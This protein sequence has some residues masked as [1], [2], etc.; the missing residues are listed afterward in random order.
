MMSISKAYKCIRE[1]SRQTA[2]DHVGAYAAQSSF[3]FI[4]AIFPLFMLLL[5]L[6]KYT[7]VTEHDLAQTAIAIVPDTL[8]PLI[9]RI[10]QE[11]YA[12]S[13]FAIISLTAIAALW[14]SSRVILSLIRGLNSIF[15]IEEKRGYFHLRIVASFYTIIFLIVIILSLGMMVFGNSLLRFFHNN[16]PPLYELAD[17]I[18]G[19]RSI[20]IPIILTVAFMYLYRIIPNQHYRFFDHLPG[21][22]FSSLGWII[23]SYVYSYYIDNYA[24][25]RLI[26]G[27]LTTV[28]F[29][30]LWIYICIYILFIGAEINIQYKEHIHAARQFITNHRDPTL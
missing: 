1:F 5:N 8:D 13:N 4:I 29:L 15:G 10:I 19:L 28:V 14:S 25:S 16:I 7:P 26:Y 6:I 3:F 23:F 18:I 30:M 12:Q 20:Y 2:Y 24:G 21:A 9:A 22:L 27:S 11:M 17:F